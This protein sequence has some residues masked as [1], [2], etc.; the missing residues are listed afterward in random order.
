MNNLATFY[1]VIQAINFE[2]RLKRPLLN[3]QRQLHATAI[4]RPYLSLSSSLV[5]SLFLRT[6]SLSLSHPLSLC[7]IRVT[8]AH[9]KGVHYITATFVYKK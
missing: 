5:P 2:E 3:D 4:F 1:R 6:L 7:H 8:R 9:E